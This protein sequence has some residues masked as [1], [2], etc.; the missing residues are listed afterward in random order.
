M[1]SSINRTQQAAG[2]TPIRGPDRVTKSA[3]LRPADRKSFINQSGQRREIEEKVEQ[4]ESKVFL[5][6]TVTPEPTNQRAGNMP[7]Q[8]RHYPTA[9][10]CVCVRCL[11]CEQ[12][13]NSTVHTHRHTQTHT[14]THTKC[15]GVNLL[16][17]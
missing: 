4:Q 2:W 13:L 11:S 6:Q 7:S 12:L 5:A 17:V 14:H 10:V 16:H 15:T 3:D 1:L 9:C 8:Q